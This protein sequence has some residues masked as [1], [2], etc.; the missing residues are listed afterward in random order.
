MIL[1]ISQP[2][3]ALSTPSAST[4]SSLDRLP[5]GCGSNRAPS[6][7]AP[8]SALMNCARCS[9][10]SRNQNA[11]GLCCTRGPVFP[12]RTHACPST[13]LAV[14][15]RRCSELVSDRRSAMPPT[16]GTTKPLPG[17]Q[18]QAS[19]PFD[20]GIEFFLQFFRVIRHGAYPL[21]AG[22]GILAFVY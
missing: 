6:L 22:H 10:A 2:S 20:T 11:G 14:R 7:L 19:G 1:T 17:V 15:G 21:S 18:H 16:W 4:P 9:T 12:Y 3:R 13:P 8:T 5:R